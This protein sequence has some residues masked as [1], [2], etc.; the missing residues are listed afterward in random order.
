MCCSIPREFYSTLTYDGGMTQPILFALLVLGPLQML[1]TAMG[2]FVGAVFG[3]S[4]AGS[5]SDAFGTGSQVLPMI[6]LYIIQIISAP[7]GLIAGILIGSGL[8][9]LGLMIVGGPRR[10]FEASLR[11][12]AF[13]NCVVIFM[14][15]PI[16]G[17]LVGGIWAIV[18]NIIG[19]AEMHDTS[20]ARS[21]F[22]V[23]YLVF[24][25]FCC[26]ILVM[27]LIGGGLALWGASV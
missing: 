9:H 18:L 19:L 25:A 8:A 12:Y 2:I 5:W 17:P 3:L 16:I 21:A 4:A 15:V 27:G 26:A 7:V 14:I 11:T 24:L 23:L 20:Y 6:P 10:N 13:S 22:A 1:V